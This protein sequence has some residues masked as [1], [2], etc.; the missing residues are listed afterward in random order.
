MLHHRSTMKI[1]TDAVLLSAW[2][3]TENTNRILDIGTGSGI[4]A[5]MMAVRTGATIDAI[6]P[7][8]GSADEAGEN[9]R[10]SPFADKL[11][12]YHQDIASF[13]AKTESKY[14]LIISNPPFFINDMRP[15]NSRRKQ[16]RHSDNLSFSELCSHSKNLLKE[17]GRFC[18]VL[19]YYESKI[20][21]TEAGKQGLFLNKRTLIFP[22]PCKEPNRVN[23]ELSNIKTA[24]INEEKFIIRDEQGN[25]T[26][27]YVNLLDKYYLSI[28]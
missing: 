27:Q 9:F 19:P 13:A 23:L 24:T 10:N 28:K 6:E 17:G 22:K 7:D 14:D 25:F 1:G 16:A 20:F 2:V 5:M 21:L 3:N 8:K 11:N 18:L 4:I 26:K 15:E 12:I